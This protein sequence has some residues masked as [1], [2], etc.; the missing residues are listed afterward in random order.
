MSDFVEKKVR[1]WG[2][3]ESRETNL[4]LQYLEK[5]LFSTYECSL[6]PHTEFWARMA[7]WIENANGDRALEIDLFNSIN[8][9]FYIGPDE[10]NELY[11]RAYNGPI[12]RWFIEKTKIDFSNIH[13]AKQ[14]LIAEVKHTWFCPISDSLRINH[15]YHLNR[16]PVTAEL[17]PDWRTLQALGDE[18]K[19]I[20]YIRHKQ[21][22]HIILL[23]DFVG[24]G[25]Q[26][27]DALIFACKFSR[28]VSILF[29]PLLICPSGLQFLKQ[30]AVSHG[31][32]ISPVLP[33]SNEIFVQSVAQSGES[34]E[35]ARLRDL[36]SKTYLS[37]TNGQ[38]PGELDSN[39]T[40]KKPYHPLGWHETGGLVVMYTNTP[41]NTLPMFH[42][43]S[44][45]WNPIFP[46]H[47]RE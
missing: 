27:R 36:A 26:A 32:D 28:Y 30:L 5:R 35:M 10:F 39:N 4:R 20:K 16:I 3:R 25:S 13:K 6:P 12:A 40:P 1:E 33:L 9:I 29:V 22:R 24:G 11:R 18:A 41:D 38:P 43:H 17:R 21:I 2:D 34:P 37:V 45:S 31:F 7:K 42:W 44:L 47:S 8:Q 14:A 46:R 15:F 23:E 19:I